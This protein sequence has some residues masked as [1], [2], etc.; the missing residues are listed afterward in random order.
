[1]GF[2]WLQEE[3]VLH[4]MLGGDQLHGSLDLLPWL[5]CEPLHRLA[6][7][8]ERSLIAYVR[9]LG[10]VVRRGRRKRGLWLE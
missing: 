2:S 6:R 7:G 5:V 8:M 4:D 1:M 10:R 9:H 3:G